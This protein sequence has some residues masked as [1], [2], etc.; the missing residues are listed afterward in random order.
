MKTI[1]ITAYAVNPYK[2]SEDGTGWNITKEVA[3]EYKVILITRKNNVPHLEKYFNENEG[4][5][6]QNITFYGFDL[7][8]WT[9]WLKKKLGAKSH[10]IYYYFWQ[11]FVS[12]F[13]KKSDFEFDIAHSLNFH[14]DSHT[15]FLWT[16]GKPTIWGPIGHHPAVPKDYLLP[17]YGLKAFAIDRFFFAGKWL[18][19]TL[20]PFRK[21]AIR[22]TS[23]II[24]INSDVQYKN[25]FD[26]EKSVIIPAIAA[27]DP[28]LLLSNKVNRPFTVLSAGRFHYMKGFDI[29]IKSFAQFR[30]QLPVA[31]QQQVKLI[32]VGQGSEQEKLEQLAI[33]CGIMEY[34]EWIPWVAYEQMSWLY[35]HA[36]LFFFPSHEGA[37][38][39]IPEAM[40][41]GLPVLTFNNVGPG[42]LYG[43]KSLGINYSNYDQSIDDFAKRLQLLHSNDM[44]LAH[45]Q[46]YSRKR[47]LSHLTWE[48]KGNQLRS[49]YD[50]LI[51]ESAIVPSFNHS[52]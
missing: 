21:I 31:S 44:V 47:F 34:I 23:K 10:V 49:I 22:R 8:N 38:M 46:T 13:I 12:R 52:V 50:S 37:G 20:D 27:I 24:V 32:L 9:L 29:V 33:A 36:D 11:Y 5:C 1:L 19:R 25:G 40:S 2:G 16:L 7:P 15:H 35:R 30:A 3:K 26:N 14:S 48:I 4:S 39:V 42:E 17:V 6:L 45:Y 28:P 41:Y 51:T 43:N 18:L